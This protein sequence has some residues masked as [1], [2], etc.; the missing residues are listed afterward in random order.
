MS[1]RKIKPRILNSG[2]KPKKHSFFGD[3]FLNQ[4]FLAIIGLTF[5]VLI[6]FPL[7]RTYSQKRIIEK[8]ISDQQKQ[9]TDFE[10]TNKE[11]TDMIAYLNSDQSLEEEARLNLNLKKSGEQVVVINDNSSEASTSSLI[12]P[13]KKSNLAKWRD[14][15]FN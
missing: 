14:Y 15:F 11:M 8:E 13:S 10:N 9:I 3:L 5:L 4:R 6:I 2:E 1:K 12:T 7:A